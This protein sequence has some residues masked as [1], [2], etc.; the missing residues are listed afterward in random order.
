MAQSVLKL[1]YFDQDVNYNKTAA[2]Q[3]QGGGAMLAKIGRCALAG[4]KGALVDVEVDLA[5]YRHQAE[6]GCRR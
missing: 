6:A 1:E 3:L 2:I 4:R 5:R